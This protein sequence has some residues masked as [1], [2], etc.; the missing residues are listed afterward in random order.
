[1][2]RVPRSKAMVKL[3]LARAGGKKRPFYRI[4]VAH[5]RDPRD[6]RFIERIGIYDPKQDPEVF[7]IDKERLDY[8][9]GVGAQA[10]ETLDRLIK[11]H[12]TEEK[13]IAS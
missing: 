7:K 1:M 13:Q 4:I 2:R 3:R 8:W 9:L 11:R 12:A 10:S 5:S 6:G